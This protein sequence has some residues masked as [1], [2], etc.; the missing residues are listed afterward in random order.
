VQ[1]VEVVRRRG[2][3]EGRFVSI[4]VAAQFDPEFVGSIELTLSGNGVTEDAAQP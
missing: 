4:T 2:V 3:F 1:K